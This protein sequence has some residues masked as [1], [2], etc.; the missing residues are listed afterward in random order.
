MSRGFWALTKDDQTA[1]REWYRLK[2]LADSV[3]HDAEPLIPPWSI[4]AIGI[5]VGILLS[6][7]RL[8][9]I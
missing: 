5:V 4:F 7:V 8:S 6:H 9:I 1:L 3:Y 2:G